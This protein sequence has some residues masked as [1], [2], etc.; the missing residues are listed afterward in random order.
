MA[1]KILEPRGEAEACFTEES[2]RDH[3]RSHQ[4]GKT[5]LPLVLAAVASHGEVSLEPVDQQEEKRTRMPSLALW[6]TPWELNSDITA[7]GLQ[8]NLWVQPLRI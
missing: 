5:S 7:Q 2:Q 3:D 1:E 4:K 6:V 8:E